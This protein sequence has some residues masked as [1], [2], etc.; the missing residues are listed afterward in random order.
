MHAHC[1]ITLSHLNGVNDW[2][3]FIFSYDCAGPGMATGV[4]TLRPNLSSAMQ[5][6]F[7]HSLS[8]ADSL[9]FMDIVIMFH[10]NTHQMCNTGF[11][12]AA[13]AVSFFCLKVNQRETLLLN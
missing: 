12:R 2:F 11:P 9:A 10:L 7:S 5:S 8:S 1:I 3:V 4:V 13:V 6:Q